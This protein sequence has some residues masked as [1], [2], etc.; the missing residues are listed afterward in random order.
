MFGISLKEILKLPLLKNVK[1]VSGEKSLDRFVTGITVAE[2]PDIVNW[3]KKNTI[4][5]S[6]LF[7]FTD[8]ES[9]RSLVRGLHTKGAA[10]L[11]VKPK[12]FY[13]R[14]PH[15]LIDEARKLDFPV[16]EIE[17]KIKW[18]DVIRAVL[19]KIIDESSAKNRELSLFQSLL[20]G[21]SEGTKEELLNY[22]KI[23]P[24][25]PFRLALLGFPFARL[26]T[27]IPNDEISYRI[28]GEFQ[29]ITGS[30]LTLEKRNGYF[31]AFP[32]SR[33]VETSLKTLVQR[34][35][36]AFGSEIVLIVS[37]DLF[38]PGEI[39]GTAEKLK[40]IFKIAVKLK[41]KENI[42][43][44]REF[45]YFLLLNSLLKMPE[46][47]QLIEKFNQNIIEATGKLM[48]KNL[49]LT[50]SAFLDSGLNKTK[51]ALKLNTHINTI[52]Y[53]LKRFEEV[54]GIDLQNTED[55]FRLYLML[56]FLK[57]KGDIK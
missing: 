23:Q 35:K 4:Y 10:A 57:L 36:N 39:Q 21:D 12:R 52:K 53:R 15:S 37:D 44:L 32:S 43:R 18:S 27:A 17:E 14:T 3:A 20:E 2:V 42:F 19:E 28:K 51:T 9:L 50:V 25:Q 1:L 30:A 56:T 41:P 45:E 48:A 55:L 47:R 22:L 7:A 5:L 24:Y 49:L 11:F 29:K 33:T 46:T 8:D 6:T 16:I 31:V 40:Q 13:D 26:K 38:D 34:L 54:T